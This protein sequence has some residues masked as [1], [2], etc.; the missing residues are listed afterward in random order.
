MTGGRG[1]NCVN[2]VLLLKCEPPLQERRESAQ[3]EAACPSCHRK[4]DGLDGKHSWFLPS[5][6]T[7]S[8]AP[9]LKQQPQNLNFPYPV[10]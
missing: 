7:F 3:P 4:L 8:P 10:A 1:T 5:L 2:L 6:P 9:E